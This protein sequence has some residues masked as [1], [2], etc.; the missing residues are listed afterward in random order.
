[1]YA[2]TEIIQLPINNSSKCDAVTKKVKLGMS[3]PTVN[4]MSAMNLCDMDKEAT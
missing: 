3:G 4:I 2:R 1:M